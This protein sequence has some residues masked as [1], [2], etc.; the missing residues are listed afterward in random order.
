[1]DSERP[2]SAQAFDRMTFALGAATGLELDKIMHWEH[3]SPAEQ[4]AFK[5]WLEEEPAIAYKT[6]PPAKHQVK[7]RA[8]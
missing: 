5:R 3:L 2:A 7:R 8:P 1:M 6:S 4:D